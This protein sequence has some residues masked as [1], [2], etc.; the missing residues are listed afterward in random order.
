MSETQ[1]I[2]PHMRALPRTIVVLVVISVTVN[3]VLAAAFVV[4]LFFITGR[5]HN[6]Q[7]DACHTSNGARHQDIAIW[8]ILID[9]PASA[10]AAERNR[11]DH[12]AQRVA[13]KDRQVNCAALYKTGL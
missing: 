6:S 5:I 13:A 12:L 2:Q 7:L 8:Q 3:V 1:E 11:Q 9:H 10:A 4:A